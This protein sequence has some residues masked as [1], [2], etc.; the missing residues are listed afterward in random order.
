MTE[1]VKSPSF[2]IKEINSAIDAL[3][4]AQARASDCVGKVLVMA[5][6][7]S[8]QGIQTGPVPDHVGVANSLLKVLR[9]ST[10][11]DAIIAFLEHFGQLYCNKAGEF[12]HF[13]LG[14]QAALEWT[15]EYVETVKLAATNWESFKA[16]PVPTDLDVEERVMKLIKDVAK[17]QK[18]GK[19]VKHAKLVAKLVNALATYHAEVGVTAE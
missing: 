8:I 14:T 3:V 11:K 6:Y 15:P 18:D 12:E 16:K 10:K 4:K 1:A 19:T 9:K 13:K 17:Q 5:V 7:A 2:S